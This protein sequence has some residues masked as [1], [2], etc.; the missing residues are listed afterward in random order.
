MIQQTVRSTD[1][2]VC[3][4]FVVDWSFTCSKNEVF[5]VNGFIRKS[6][7]IGKLNMALLLSFVCVND[8]KMTGK[9]VIIVIVNNNELVGMFR[10]REE[11]QN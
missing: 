7:I 5:I 4:L 3:Q 9:T 6:N 11:L 2:K 1:H 8:V 10:R